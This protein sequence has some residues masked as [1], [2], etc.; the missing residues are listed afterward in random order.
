MY[1]YVM[2]ICVMRMRIIREAGEIGNFLCGFLW[3]KIGENR[4]VGAMPERWESQQLQE[5]M[6]N[7]YNHSKTAQ[8][9]LSLYN[10]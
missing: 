6:L 4:S 1:T 7:A 10:T 9:R 8:N 2:R 3:G 5:P